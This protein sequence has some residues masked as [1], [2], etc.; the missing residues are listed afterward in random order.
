M[1]GETGERRVWDPASFAKDAATLEQN[2]NTEL[3]FGRIGMI[4]AI[5]MITEEFITG[6]PVLSHFQ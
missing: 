5:G 4:G 3:A 6:A 2:K 1:G